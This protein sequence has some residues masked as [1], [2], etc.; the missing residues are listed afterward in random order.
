MD[1][2]HVQHVGTIITCIT[3]C[4]ILSDNS[5]SVKLHVACCDNQSVLKIL[6]GTLIYF[7]IISALNTLII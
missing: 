6:L 3:G 2:L 5:G 4:M 1:L 7:I